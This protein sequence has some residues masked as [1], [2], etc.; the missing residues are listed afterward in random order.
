MS[1]IYINPD[2]NAMPNAHPLPYKA[3]IFRLAIQAANDGDGGDINPR[4]VLMTAPDADHAIEMVKRLYGDVEVVRCDVERVIQDA[5]EPRERVIEHVIEHVVEHTESESVRG[6]L[7]I[8]D[9]AVLFGL[10]VLCD[11]LFWHL[12][13]KGWL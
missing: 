5:P 9:L 7:S 2:T 6:Y 8:F 1:K 3:I 13:A 4:S 12:V 11:R 10:G